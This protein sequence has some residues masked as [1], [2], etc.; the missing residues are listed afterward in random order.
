MRNYCIKSQ[1]SL[2]GTPTLKHLA[3]LRRL[4][5]VIQ[6]LPWQSKITVDLLRRCAIRHEGIEQSL[7][8]IEDINWLLES[9]LAQIESPSSNISNLPFLFV[10]GV[11]I[12]LTYSCNLA[13]SHCLQAPL[14]D[15]NQHGWLDESVAVRFLEQ[16]QWLGLTRLG[17]NITGGETF[18]PGSPILEILQ[19]TNHLGIATRANTNAWWGNHK[20]IIIGKN[21]FCSDEELVN[22][23][24]EC[25][26]SR[27]A[28]SLDNRYEQ[29]PELLDRVIRIAFLCENHQLPYEFVSTEPNTNIRIK[30]S[31]AL[32]KAIGRA[33][34]FMQITPMKVVDIGAAKPSNLKKLVVENLDQLA[35]QSPC[36]GAG[37][38]RPYYLHMA[39]DGGIRS[40]LYAPGGGWYGNMFHQSLRDILN[41]VSCKLVIQIF[42]Q[43][44]LDSFVAK[45]LMPWQHYYRSIG[46]SCT[47]SAL[48][49]RLAEQIYKQEADQDHPLSPGQ[50][51]AIHITISKELGLQ[52]VHQA[53]PEL[54]IH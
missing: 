39:P 12:E 33:P 23:L 5:L 4:S 3:H 6:D 34:K 41:S 11:N 26:L 44:R 27:L 46:H 9:G 18:M 40:C 42:E 16:A 50:I 38:H 7:L 29:Y 32:N 54:A 31:I 36:S 21:L 14:R 13:C 45:Y 22:R 8:L 49:A 24:C 28:L 53:Q 37:F 47:A 48:I 30:A 52:A 10:K 2:Y 25:G 15:G 51:D 1:S 43:K 17:C 20:N 19:R 35:L